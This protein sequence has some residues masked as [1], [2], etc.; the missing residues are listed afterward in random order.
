MVTGV[1]HSVFYKL[2]LLSE[3]NRCD[4]NLFVV[5]LRL[6]FTADPSTLGLDADRRIKWEEAIEQRRARKSCHVWCGK[7]FHMGL[8][9]LAGVISG[10]SMGSC[11]KA[12]L[13]L[14]QLRSL[15]VSCL[16]CTTARC[17]STWICTAVLWIS[18][19]SEAGLNNAPRMFSLKR[20]SF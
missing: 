20:D 7:H 4:E 8:L 18:V 11:L 14:V 3:L 19:S 12:M 1:S 6:S 13:V 10:L 15:G 9:L 5:N 17:G 16:C 2:C